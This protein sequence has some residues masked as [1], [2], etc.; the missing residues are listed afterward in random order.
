MTVIDSFKNINFKRYRTLFFIMSI[1]FLIIAGCFEIV[2]FIYDIPGFIEAFKFLFSVFLGTLSLFIASHSLVLSKESSEIA[3]SSDNKMKS[4]VNVQFLQ[5]VNMLEDARA[6][7]IGGIYKPD[8]LGWKSQNIIE[9]A[10]EL[11]K[12]DEEKKF[13]KPDYQ[14]KLF[15]Y[16]NISFIH[17]F[18]YKKWEEEKKSV[19]T[20]IS[21]FA[22]AYAMIEDYYNDKRKKELKDFIKTEPK[23]DYED[24]FNRVEQ[25][26]KKLMDEN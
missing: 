5:A 6:Y 26:K 8:L 16:F 21:N 9:M 15:H 25:K 3:T 18:A 10:V 19:D 14:D 20:G 22:K 13:I 2:G 17:L 23:I 4:I 12:R 7:F 11:L 1:A 24:F